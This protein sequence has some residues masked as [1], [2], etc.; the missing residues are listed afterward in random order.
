LIQLHSD[1]DTLICHFIRTL[2]LAALRAFFFLLLF[3]ISSSSPDPFAYTRSTLLLYFLVFFT[4]NLLVELLQGDDLVHVA[5]TLGLAVVGYS[6][7][8]GW[9][10]SGLKA[11]ED[12]HVLAIAKNHERTPAQVM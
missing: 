4:V 10:L 12:R 3:S 5:A 9:P 7:L 8:S 6:T 1:F 2:F 11:T